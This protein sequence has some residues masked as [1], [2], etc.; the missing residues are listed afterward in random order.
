MYLSAFGWWTGVKI[1][2]K[3]GLVDS[4]KSRRAMEIA[5]SASKSLVSGVNT[6]RPLVGLLYMPCINWLFFTLIIIQQGTLSIQRFWSIA[7][8][9]WIIAI[10]CMSI[11]IMAEHLGRRFTQLEI[12]SLQFFV[13]KYLLGVWLAVIVAWAILPLQNGSEN[14]AR[15]PFLV[16]G[17]IGTIEVWLI[18]AAR[19]IIRQRDAHIQMEGLLKAAELKAVK[20]KLNPHFLFNSLNLI[21]AEIRER[22]EVATAVIRDLSDLLR[23]VLETHSRALVP[24]ATEMDLIERY[25]RIQA[26]RFDPGLSFEIEVDERTKQFSFPPFLLQPI[27]ENAVTHNIA[28]RSKVHIRIHTAYRDGELEIVVADNGVGFEPERARSGFGLQ[29]VRDTLAMCYGEQHRFSVL[30]K[31]G[32]GTTV[33]IVLPVVS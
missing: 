8:L 3:I 13:A 31:P 15:N 19:H 10:V 25:L 12:D 18:A 5:T 11:A 23:G 32:M 16:P 6:S 1:L 14:I 22:P 27:V 24:I 20:S 33:T 26:T 7:L 30:S 21:T 28:I 2:W 4:G 29:I 17:I 9:L